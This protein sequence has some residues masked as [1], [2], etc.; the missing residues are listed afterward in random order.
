MLLPNPNGRFLT[1]DEGRLE[2][3]GRVSVLGRADRY[4]NSGGEKI[5][6]ALVENAF[7]DAGAA[8]VLVVGERDAE[9]G[10][11]VVA[12]V[13]E[14]IPEDLCSRARASLPAWMM[15]KRIIGVPALPF[16]AKGKLDREKLSE[17]LR[18]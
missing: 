7:R 18:I 14:P 16:D 3:S 17:F 2:E 13:Q 6:P 10:E 8:S 4:I 12:L 15:P 1:G 9:W 11:R 5:D